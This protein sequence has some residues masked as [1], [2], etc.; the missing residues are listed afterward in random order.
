MAVSPVGVGEC[1]G[2]KMVIGLRGGAAE[3]RQ[4]TV[5]CAHAAAHSIMIHS[6]SGG[7]LVHSY[8]HALH[9]ST[10][11]S[12]GMAPQAHASSE[13]ALVASCSLEELEALASCWLTEA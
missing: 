10:Q 3:H 7:L 12:R 4:W 9:W 1:L 8:N 6:V 2:V 11:G 5:V 13:R